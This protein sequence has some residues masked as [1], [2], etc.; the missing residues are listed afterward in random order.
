MAIISRIFQWPIVALRLR[1]T[2]RTYGADLR[3]GATEAFALQTD[4]AVRLNRQLPPAGA[5]WRRT[6]RARVA[7]PFDF[8]RFEVCRGRAVKGLNVHD[9]SP[10]ATTPAAWHVG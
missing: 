8:Q 6:G 7:R 2:G 1:G 5:G 4:R 9:G 10:I 3:T